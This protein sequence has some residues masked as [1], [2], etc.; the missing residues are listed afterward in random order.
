[1]AKEPRKLIANN[2]KARQGQRLAILCSFAATCKANG[3]CFRKLW[4]DCE[5][6]IF[7]N[8]NLTSKIGEL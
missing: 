2:K 1:M 3:I 6:F 8:K 4:D 5:C 7:F